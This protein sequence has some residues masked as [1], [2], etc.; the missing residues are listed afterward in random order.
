MLLLRTGD[1]LA[2]TFIDRLSGLADGVVAV[3]SST[4]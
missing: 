1:L 3:L 4:V 2:Q